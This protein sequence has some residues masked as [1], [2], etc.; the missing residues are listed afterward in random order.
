MATST[1][2]FYNKFKPVVKKALSQTP[3]VMDIRHMEVRKDNFEA[4]DEAFFANLISAKKQTDGLIYDADVSE[5]ILRHRMK[6][7]LSMSAAMGVEILAKAGRLTDALRE[8]LS[9]NL[10]DPRKVPPM[11]YMTS[12]QFRL[13]ALKILAREEQFPSGISDQID[14]CAVGL[15][16]GWSDY[17]VASK[18]DAY[19]G[20]AK[21]TSRDKAIHSPL[22]ACHVAVLMDQVDAPAKQRAN[23]D[24]LAAYAS[25]L[26]GNPLGIP[27]F[28]MRD[29]PIPFG[30][31][32]TPI[33]AI[34]ASWL[35]ANVS[36]G[37]TR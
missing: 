37:A 34:C 12:E 27:A 15:D 7:E 4:I 26:A 36:T 11:G 32:I 14:A 9:T 19:M 30:T 28:Q 6:A 1:I 33:E 20:T 13:A 22:V 17:S 10:C 25:S 8:E 31:D 2:A 18:V 5:T 23:S 35:I 24:R 3:Y 16:Y 21:R 29:V